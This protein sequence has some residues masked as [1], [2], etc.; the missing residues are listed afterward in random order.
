MNYFLHIKWQLR[1]EIREKVK[2]KRAI[3]NSVNS[4]IQSSSVHFLPTISRSNNKILQIG[5]LCCFLATASYCVFSVSSSIRNYYKYD[6]VTSLKVIEESPTHFTAMSFCSL[7]RLN[8]ISSK[9]FISDYLNKMNSSINYLKE[10]FGEYYEITP[11][12]MSNSEFNQSEEFRRSI[13]FESDD[14]L[15]QCN[16]KWI[17]WSKSDI[18]YLYDPIYGNCFTF[19]NQL[20]L[21]Q[22]TSQGPS[23]GLV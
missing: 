18:N 21:K 14:M 3:K 17:P 13:G 23:Y 1:I 16:F 7:K 10:I 15:L 9:D 12:K 22:V 8:K 11:L 4:W 20:I 6:T 5:Y 19:N 2:F